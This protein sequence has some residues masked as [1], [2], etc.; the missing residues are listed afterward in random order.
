MAA[1][2]WDA[3]E[4]EVGLLDSYVGHAYGDVRQALDNLRRT[5][6]KGE[7]FVTSLEELLTEFGR[8][9]R[10]EARLSTENGHGPICFPPLV[11][12]QLE[13]VIQEALTNVS[14]HAQA[15]RVQVT[16]RQHEAGWNVVIADDGVGFEVVETEGQMRGYGLETMR[17]RV[18][19]LQGDLTIESGPGRGTRIS[20][21]VP[22]G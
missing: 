11:E 1:G 2:D 19:S 8:R 9:H 16:I 15:K 20:V 5:R 17:E 22:C 14:R 12:V 10:I 3:A 13:R 7:T 18:E 21:F 4:R 6:P